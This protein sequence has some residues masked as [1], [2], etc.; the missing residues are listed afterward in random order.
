MVLIISTIACLLIIA[1][2]VYKKKSNYLGLLLIPVVF[3]FGLIG[4]TIPVETKTEGVKA[5]DFMCS[6][7]LGA[8]EV[9][10]PNEKTTVAFSSYITVA[11]ICKESIFQK[12]TQLNSY[13]YPIGCSYKLLTIKTD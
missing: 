11:N 7:T 4:G 13:G 8:C 5:I 10:F 1:T 3:G 12:E 9:L 6:K 2:S